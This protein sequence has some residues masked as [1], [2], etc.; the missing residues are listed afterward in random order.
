MGCHFLLQRIFPTQG[1]NRGLP[2]CRQTLCR[3]SHQGSPDRNWG[4]IIFSP[5]LGKPCVL[6]RSHLTLIFFVFFFQDTS[7][8]MMRERPSRCRETGEGGDGPSC[9]SDRP[10]VGGVRAPGGATGRCVFSLLREQELGVG[11][12]RCV[13]RCEPELETCLKQPHW[14]L[15][16]VGAKWNILYIF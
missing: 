16:Y 10:R 8:A 9:L 13:Q 5:Q 12:H 6:L 2:H 3:L 15:F 7:K 11:P 1:S 4:L 14:I